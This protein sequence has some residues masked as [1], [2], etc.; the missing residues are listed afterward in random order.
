MTYEEVFQTD[1]TGT[2][3]LA[4]LRCE[5]AMMAGAET[6]DERDLLRSK[7]RRFEKELRR[8]DGPR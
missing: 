8:E 5:C 7:I 4:A 6:Q 1:T 2:V 3:V